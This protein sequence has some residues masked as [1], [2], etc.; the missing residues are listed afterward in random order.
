MIAAGLADSGTVR[1]VV[2]AAG[3]NHGGTGGT[4]GFA[5]VRTVARPPWLGNRP[6]VPRTVVRTEMIRPVLGFHGR[7]RHGAAVMGPDVV[8]AV[9]GSGAPRGNVIIGPDQADG[10][11]GAAERVIGIN[12]PAPVVPVNGIA[13]IVIHVGRAGA[14]AAVGSRYAETVIIG[15]I[16][17][18]QGAA[19][20]CR[21]QRIL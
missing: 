8:P 5:E 3:M 11:N 21:Q 12:G 4:A 19:D 6:V 1:A 18:G 2:A 15:I 7:T 13:G 10:V 20:G 17:T 9:I 14:A 16:A